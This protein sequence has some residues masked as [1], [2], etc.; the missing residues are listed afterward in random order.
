[1]PSIAF[2]RKLQ[3]NPVQLCDTMWSCVYVLVENLASSSLPARVSDK[4]LKRSIKLLSLCKDAVTINIYSLAVIVLVK[5][6]CRPVGPFHFGHHHF[7]R[8]RQKSV[9][10]VHM[11]SVVALPNVSSLEVFTV[12]WFPPSPSLNHDLCY[13][14]TLWL[15]II[16]QVLLDPSSLV[17]LLI[18]N[19]IKIRIKENSKACELK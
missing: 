5:T 8:R 2:G 6:M 9:F 12:C 17:L 11:I 19:Q 4:R 3:M 18:L 15:L 16:T 7:A 14:T 10:D 13:N 1:M